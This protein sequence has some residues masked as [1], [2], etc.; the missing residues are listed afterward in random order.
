MQKDG[1]LGRVHRGREEMTSVS[2]CGH[3]SVYVETGKGCWK[4]CGDGDPRGG[5]RNNEYV[6]HKRR[7]ARCSNY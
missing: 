5:H 6:L 4:G 3:A 7:E 1:F 2:L